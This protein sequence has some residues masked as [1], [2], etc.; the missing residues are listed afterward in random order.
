MKKYIS[1]IKASM[2]EGM[3]LFRI[4]T[5]NKN[6]FTKFFLPIFLV[7]MLM[8]TV[9]F[10]SDL[11]MKELSKVN[12]EFVLIT[13]FIIFT[14]IMTLVEGIYK[15]GN[16]LFNC[17][18]DNLLLSLPIRRGTVLLIR[19]FKFYIFEL[20]YNSVFL[21]PAMIVYAQYTKPSFIYYIVSLVGLLV[22]PI[23]PILVA[24]I[25]GTFITFVASKFKGK[26][27][28]QTIITVIFLLVILYFS[29]NLQNF[30]NDIAQN[31]SSINDLITKLYYPAGAFVELILKFNIIKLL[32]FILVNMVLFVL[33]ILLMSKLYFNINSSSKSIKISKIK[34]DYKIKTS[35]P[36]GALIKKEFSR[37]INSPVFVTNAGFGLVLFI[38]GTVLLAVKF[39][40]FADMII[41]KESTMDLDYIK[42]CMPVLLFGFICFTS[43]MTSITSSM[44]SLEGKSFSILKSLPIKPYT[45]I[46]SKVLTAV[47]VM[48]PCILLGDIIVF[49]RFQFDLFSIIL[50]LLISI[51]LPL[52]AETLGIIV[53]LKYPRMDAKNDTEVV[54]QSMSS[55]ISVFIGMAIIG[56]TIVLLY[57]ALKA[58]IS[59]NTIMLA[60][61]NIYTIIYL[62]LVLFLHKTCEKSFDNINV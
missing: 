6:T 38:L 39:D 32:E 7:L 30:I 47:I 49:I 24:S 35:T 37:F 36:M 4:S 50:T 48:I 60:F 12:M 57:N 29:Y 33:T 1:L 23:I 43:F 40:S 10:Y 55:S 15:S 20:L 53:N 25:L 27:F 45:I 19:V 31:A 54:K 41:Q 42:S 52:I 9:Y 62:V 13:L 8:G 58:N 14:S 46:E 3:N 16:L 56:I 5:K 26:N 11:L 51:L 44:I 17:K 59:N 22:F 28:V 18:D 34:K 2:T 61:L 21:L